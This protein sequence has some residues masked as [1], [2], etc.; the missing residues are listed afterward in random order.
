[1]VNFPT[2]YTRMYTEC[3][4]VTSNPGTPIKPLF[5][6]QLDD[7]GHLELVQDGEENIYDY[8]QSH[9]DSVDIH[10][11]MQRFEAG[12]MDA[13]NRVQGT[14]ADLTTMPKTYAEMLNAVIAGE[15]YFSQ[16]PLE[17][18]ARFGHSFRQWMASMD[19]P[20]F[21]EKMGWQ[22]HEQPVAGSPEVDPPA[23]PAGTPSGE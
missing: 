20:D 6:P 14:Y 3:E 1:M 10:K 19:S 2:M 17:V 5:R 18:R 16:L 7:A 15:Q 21:A 23:A 13:L 12:D 22:A 11:I 4:R 9:R 8:I